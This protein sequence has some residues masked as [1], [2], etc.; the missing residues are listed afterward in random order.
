MFQVE[1]EFEDDDE[2]A[3]SPSV[4]SWPQLLLNSDSE[5]FNF[6]SE[7]SDN[8]APPFRSHEE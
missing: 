5:S 6:G 2:L 1:I 4:P 3:T 7:G 8:E